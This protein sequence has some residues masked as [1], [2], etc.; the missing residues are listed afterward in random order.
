[1]GMSCDDNRIIK[2]TTM[3]MTV[4]DDDDGR[5][6]YDTNSTNEGDDDCFFSSVHM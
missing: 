2:I 5:G 6:T 1:M 3:M 4:I